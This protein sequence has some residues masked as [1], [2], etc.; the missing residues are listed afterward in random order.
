MISDVVVRKL[1]ANMV[2][3]NLIVERLHRWYRMTPHQQRM[4]TMRNRNMRPYFMT[5]DR[6]MPGYQRYRA[7]KQW[8]PLDT[9]WRS[10]YGMRI[11]R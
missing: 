4:E 7:I 8:R 11:W 5:K 9:P 6:R 2:A 10:V 3:P 1:Y